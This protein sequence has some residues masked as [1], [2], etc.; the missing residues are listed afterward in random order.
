MIG[1]DRRPN[2]WNE[3]VN[4]ITL[5]ADLCDPQS[6][7][8]IPENVDMVVHLAAN[9]RVYNLVVDPTQAM[10]NFLM[11]FHILEFCRV[12]TIHKLIFS[13]SREV[14]GNSGLPIHTEE[15]A[16]VRHCESPYTASKIGGEALVHAYAQCYGIN[17]IITR[18]SN[19]YG[20]YDDSDRVIP[21]FIRKTLNNED[22]MVYG[23][24]KVLDF[25][26]IDD[27][28]DGIIRCIE[29]FPEEK[30]SV[31]NIASG[32]S[33]RITDVADEII[34]FMEG[35]NAVILGENRTGEV[36]QSSID[37]SRARERLGYTPKTR[38]HEGVAAS[39]DWYTKHLYTDI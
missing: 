26:Y 13:S 29:Q 38:I 12:N 17:F 18:F 10:E 28:I 22:L 32:K 19:V 35:H 3:S 16:Y 6:L 33:V 24:D 20:M 23:K 39:V 31:F 15:E 11:L 1:L 8:V 7:S 5:I 25:T 14:Y 21:L 9:A 36:V 37:I 34:R 30:N 27:T 4:E 2:A